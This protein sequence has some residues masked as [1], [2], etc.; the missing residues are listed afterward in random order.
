MGMKKIILGLLIAGTFVFAAWEQIGP[1]GGNVRSVVASYA[2]DNI[3]YATSYTSPTGVA[4]SINGGAAW[5][6]TNLTNAYVY[7][8][9]VNPSVP[10]TVCASGMS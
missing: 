5:S 6:S 3:V 2:N 1:Y 4:K 10:A 9:I 8:I 7:G